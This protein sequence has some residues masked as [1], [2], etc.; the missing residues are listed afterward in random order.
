VGLTLVGR[1]M[2][3]LMSLTFE[4]P[5]A[6]GAAHIRLAATTSCAIA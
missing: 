4:T 6:G 2:I 1:A 5:V 3:V